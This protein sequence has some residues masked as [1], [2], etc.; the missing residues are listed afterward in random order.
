MKLMEM[1]V[2]HMDMENDDFIDVLVNALEKDYGRSIYRFAK[3]KQ[4]GKYSWQMSIIFT[5]FCLL[6]GEMHIVTP[7]P[8][9]EPQ[10]E[11][12]GVYY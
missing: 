4:I 6:E 3:A 7:Y 9:A 12:H 5:D 1:N 11:I 8:G 10:V 2:H